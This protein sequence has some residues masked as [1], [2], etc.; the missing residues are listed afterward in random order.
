MA[1]NEDIT[2]ER[3]TIEGVGE[4]GPGETEKKHGQG[5]GGGSLWK[6]LKRRQGP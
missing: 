6:L 4:Q 1:E 5:G 3:K 2:G